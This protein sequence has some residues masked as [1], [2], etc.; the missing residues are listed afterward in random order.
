[1]FT[2][3]FGNYLLNKKLVSSWQLAE[4]LSLQKT[5]RLKLGVMAINAGYMTAAQ[6]DEV[7]N[8]QQRVDKRIGDIAVSMGYLTEAQVNELLSSQ[9]TGHL[10]L[11]QALVDKGYMTNSQFESALKDYKHNNSLTDADFS[12]NQGEKV[13][14]L[15]SNFYHFNALNNSTVFTEYVSLFLKNIIRFIGDDFTPLEGKIISNYHT[16]WFAAQEVRSEYNTF[17]AI[18]TDENSFITFAGRYADESFTQNDEYTQASIGEF[19]NLNN[20]LFTVNMSNDHQLELELTPQTISL[21]KTFATEGV[22]FTVPI[23][24]SFGTITLLLSSGDVVIK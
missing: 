14:D 5:T 12:T 19:L 1:M 7:H 13:S 8:E 4:A 24:F 18:D 11:G 15:I 10:L 6:V 16:S 9:K 3:F 21:G 20:G 17:T 2:Q 22:I 23:C